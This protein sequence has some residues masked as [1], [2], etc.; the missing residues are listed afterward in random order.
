MP[1]SIRPASANCAAAIEHLKEASRQR[2]KEKRTKKE[3][4]KKKKKKKKKKARS[5]EDN[6]ARR[7]ATD[8]CAVEDYSQRRR[9]STPSGSPS[10]P[11][12][13][14]LSRSTGTLTREEESFCESSNTLTRDNQGQEA[15]RKGWFKSLSRKNKSNAACSKTPLLVTPCVTYAT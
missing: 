10:P 1:G 15:E 2:I 4:E 14:R 5:K 6:A 7:K 13:T 3:E 12:P 11:R 8:E 9:L